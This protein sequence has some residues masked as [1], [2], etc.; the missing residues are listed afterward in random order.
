MVEQPAVIARSRRKAAL[1]VLCVAVFAM[2]SIGVASLLHPG[3][4]PQDPHGLGTRITREVEPLYVLLIGSDSRKNTALYTGKASEHAQVD[5]HSDIMTL[6]RID[7]QTYTVTLVTIPRDTQLAGTSGKINDSLAGG[8][9]NE[10][11]KVVETLTGISV[12]YYMMTTFTSF[13]ALV[14]DLGGTVVDVPLKITTD[15]PSTGRDVTVNAGQAQLLDGSQTLVLARARKEYV[16]DQD[17]LRQINVRNIEVSLINKVL[18]DPEGI[19]SALSYLEEHIDTDMDYGLIA[20]LVADFLLHREEVTIYTCTGPH[21]GSVNDDGLWVI[22]EDRETWDI[23]ME[24]VDAGIDPSGI[25]SLPS[26]LVP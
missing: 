3:S 21:Q 22:P 6:M 1:A 20:S 5:Q 23:L 9:P 11:V 13:E 10:V 7:P 25:V 14:D 4:T 17:A 16:D 15:D 18:S 2:A 12:D 8:D 24:A 19:D 26:F